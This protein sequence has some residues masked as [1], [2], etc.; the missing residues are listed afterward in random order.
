MNIEWNSVVLGVS[1]VMVVASLVTFFVTS[2]RHPC[3][4]CLNSG[5]GRKNKTVK[6]CRMFVHQKEP[7]SPIGMTR[8][9][10][11]IFRSCI[12][13]ERHVVCTTKTMLMPDRKIGVKPSEILEWDSVY[14]DNLCKRSNVK[15]PAKSGLIVFKTTQ[16]AVVA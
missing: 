2:R 11:Y 9:T 3:Q 5:E 14:I 4:F 6:V 1:S 16:R 13:H 8:V 7:D 10:I 12:Q 15:N